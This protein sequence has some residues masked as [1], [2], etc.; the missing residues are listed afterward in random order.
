[1]NINVLATILR[2]RGFTAKVQR[3]DD[4]ESTDD[5]IEVTDAVHVQVGYDYMGVG[6]IEGEGD[7][8][9]FWQWDMRQRD[10]VEGLV[11]DLQHALAGGRPCLARFNREHGS[12]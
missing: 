2:A 7:D 12:T 5:A 11:A 9:V 10:D 6:L 4:F 8:V 1:M 3:S